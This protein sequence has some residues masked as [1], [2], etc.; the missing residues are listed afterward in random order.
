ME[1]KHAHN[2]TYED[3]DP[4]FKWRREET[5]DTIEL[6]LPAFKREQV[7]IKINHVGLLVISG[8]HHLSGTRWRRFKKE[9]EI[10]KYCNEDAVHGNFMQNIL[11][12]V[13][14]KK[15]PLIPQEDHETPIPEFEHEKEEEEE[16][17]KEKEA[18][19]KMGHGAREV[20]AEETARSIDNQLAENDV[21]LTLETTR[22]VAFKFMVVIIVILLIVSYLA[23]MSKRIMAQAQ[24]YLQN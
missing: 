23:D 22:E 3:F 17:E 10:P 4:V 7:R 9:F 1:A 14:P 15:I 20:V 12:V 19:Q 2:R 6:Y 16:K 13:L 21:G 11:S 24:S 18:Y 5:R 8:E